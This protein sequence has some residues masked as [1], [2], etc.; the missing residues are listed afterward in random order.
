MSQPEMK[1]PPNSQKNEQIVL[2]CMLTSIGSL[3]IAAEALEG[4]DFYYSEHKI[5]FEILKG[6]FLQ[7]KPA[8]VHLVA[9]ELKRRNQLTDVGGIAYLI[10]IAQY[11]GTAAHIE[12]YT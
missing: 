8:D 9:E 12:E 11:A 7:D 4:S 10:S 3:N 6:Y 1:I 5:I 2:G